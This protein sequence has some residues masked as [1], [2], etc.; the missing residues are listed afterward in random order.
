MNQSEFAAA[1][2]KL[3]REATQPSPDI[4]DFDR[5]T[6]LIERAVSPL[7]PSDPGSPTAT[8]EAAMRA[9]HEQATDGSLIIYYPVGSCLEPDGKTVVDNGA[10]A[11]RVLR[12]L[13]AGASVSLPAD[14]GW[15]V[16]RIDT[17]PVNPTAAEVRERVAAS[18]DQL[19][20]DA[21]SHAQN[22]YF[23]QVDHVKLSFLQ[24]AAN[25]ERA[26]AVARNTTI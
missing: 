5:L 26:A 1:I 19:A 9:T 24:A 4:A 18:I 3:R 17:K 8:T 21:R 23:A 12:A 14:S 25:F 15:R 20:A 2:S 6:R 16:E 22:N 11:S 10:M 7:L 13:G